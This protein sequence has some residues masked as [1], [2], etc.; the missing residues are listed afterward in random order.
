MI[1]HPHCAATAG[2]FT[3]AALNPARVL[4]PALVFGCGWRA[5]PVYIAAQVLGAVLASLVSWPLYGT[6]LQVSLA[7][8]YGSLLVDGVCNTS[9][10]YMASMYSPCVS[11]NILTAAC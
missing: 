11:F 2:S 3:G 9:W 8:L 1:H 5:V 6:G 4:G 10:R 7:D